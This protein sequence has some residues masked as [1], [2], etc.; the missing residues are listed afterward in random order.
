M[1]LDTSADAYPCEKRTIIVS[2]M[3]SDS[4]TWNLVFLQL[5]LEEL[6]HSVINLG[7]C[8]PDDLLVMECL[9]QRPD[10]VVLSSVNGHGLQDGLR[11]IRDLRGHPELAGL[12]IVIGGK[13]GIEGADARRAPALISAGFDA[14]FES[15]ASGMALFRSFLNQLPQGVHCDH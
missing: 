8:V 7:A 2:S 12:P 9:S 4:H 11:V 10:L 6:G 13:L 5:L 14:V 3:A 15:G 1:E